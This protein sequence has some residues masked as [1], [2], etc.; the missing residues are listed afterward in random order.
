MRLRPCWESE[1]INQIRPL[2][3]DC[4]G[5]YGFVSGHASNAAA[6]VTFLL[7]SFKNIKKYFRY[8]LI[9]WVLI[10][11]Y[12]RIYLA[13][14]YPLD[15]VFGIFFGFI[16]GFFIFKIYSVYMKKTFK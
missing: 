7:F 4:G 8:I 10:V 12:S 6:M 14:H 13:K 15:V 5:K 3:V 11:S 1:L 16:I 2:L 9:F